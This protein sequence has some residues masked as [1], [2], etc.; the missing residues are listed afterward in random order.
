MFVPGAQKLATAAEPR[1]GAAFNGVL[2]SARQLTSSRVHGSLE[3]VPS[4]RSPG[5][6][7]AGQE[8]NPGGS[9]RPNRGSPKLGVGSMTPFAPAACRLQRPRAI[10][11]SL[12][13]AWGPDRTPTTGRRRCAGSWETS[14][15]TRTSTTSRARSRSS[16][17]WRRMRGLPRRASA[18]T[19]SDG[20]RGAGRDRLS[21]LCFARFSTR[22]PRELRPIE[23]AREGGAARPG[24]A[25]LR[26]YA[27]AG[28]RRRQR[29]RLGVRL[30]L[31]GGPPRWTSGFVQAVAAQAF[32]RAGVLL[33]HGGRLASRRVRPPRDWWRARSSARRR[34]V[35]TRVQLF[36]TSRSS[37]HNSSRSFLSWNTWTSPTMKMPAP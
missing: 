13:E 32:A 4:S 25:A 35:G 19:R 16:R 30:P 6:R 8:L 22:P 34:H 20:H 27:G 10:A 29:P 14:R 21:A 12:W 3:T 23:R 17:C 1:P 15:P 36:A 18:P 28:G 2:R 9:R 37:T 31:H 11:Q 26:R 5:R 24:R 7:S 33:D